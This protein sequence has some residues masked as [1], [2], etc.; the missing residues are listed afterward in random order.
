M[1]LI[2]KNLTRFSQQGATYF[3]KPG[4]I[5]R[6]Q[7][8]L[9]KN[10]YEVYSPYPDAEKKILYRKKNFDVILYKIHTKGEIRHQ[11]ILG[12]LYSLSIADDLFGDIVFYEGNW[13][14]FVLS[15]VQNYLESNFLKVRGCEVS[16][17]QVSLDTL[18][19]YHRSYEEISLMVSSCRIDSI[20]SSILHVSRGMID[21]YL[22]RKEVLLQDEVLTNP[23][24]ILKEGDTFS[25][26][27][28]GK[29]S[30]AGVTGKTKGG[31]LIVKVC[32]YLS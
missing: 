14:F 4:D 12:T 27:R 23:S 31:R 19:D 32:K 20:L 7:Y 10:E 13:Y 5:L 16:L 11:D 22:K 3:L 18:E 29:F 21:G 8:H 28:V 26:R 24:K 1:Y 17:E 25:I 15:L 9:K 30:F 2:Q 6:L